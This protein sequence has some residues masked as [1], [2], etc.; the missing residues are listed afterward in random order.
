MEEK[1]QEAIDYIQSEDIPNAKSILIELVHAR[2]PS[3]DC[4]YMMMYCMKTT[5]QKIWC[6]EEVLQ[7]KADHADALKMLGLLAPGHQMYTGARYRPEKHS[8][9]ETEEEP[10]NW[11]VIVAT[12]GTVLVLTIVVIVLSSFV[13]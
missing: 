11:V 5:Q 7:I 9:E 8:K 6:L 1:L 3:G 13:F 4:W 12:L 10:V 2:Y